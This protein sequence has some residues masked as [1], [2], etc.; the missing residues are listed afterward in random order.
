MENS[1][2]ETVSI[3][4]VENYWSTFW[5]SV[6]W[7]IVLALM[8]GYAVVIGSTALQWVMGIMW[9]FALISTVHESYKKRRFTLKQAKQRIAELE[10]ANQ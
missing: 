1:K 3:I 7:Y 4:L 6:A 5:Q 10:N 2:Q 8:I 9:C